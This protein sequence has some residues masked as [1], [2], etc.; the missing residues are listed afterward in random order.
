[1]VPAW[2]VPAEH[3]VIRPLWVIVAFVGLLRVVELTR[4]TWPVESRLV[5]V[6]SVVDHR[7]LVRAPPMLDARG[8]G[9][10]VAWEVTG[11]LAFRGLL[12]MGH[13][14]RPADWLVRWLLALVVVYNLSAG[15]YRV[16]EA[17]YR[18]IGFVPPPLHVTPAAARSV[19]EFWGER[20]NR[21]VSLWLG[22][23]FFWPLARRRRPLLG[24]VSAFVVSAVL[25]AYIAWIAVGWGFGAV[26]FGYFVAQALVILL[27]RALGV[28]SWPRW[29]GHAWA[30]AWMAGLSPLFTEPMAR[31]FGC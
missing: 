20:W 28:R 29:A 30:I 15:A 17:A 24:A 5:H 8:L 31:A 3:T 1:M 27:E 9:A 13:P 18:A 10:A 25:H 21:T 6:L 14:A 4:G 23:T 19:Q 11:W 26:T 12:A 7:R 16:L 2:L 22:E